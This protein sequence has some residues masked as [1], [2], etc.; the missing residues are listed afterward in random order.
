MQSAQKPFPFEMLS[1]ISVVGMRKDYEIQRSIST[2]QSQVVENILDKVAAY[3]GI[4]PDQIKDKTRV[5]KIVLARSIAQYF[6]RQMLNLTFLEIATMF[7]QDHSTVVHAC[8]NVDR[9]LK[10]KHINEYKEYIED[11]K[12]II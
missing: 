1:Y 9:M 7:E 10:A 5:R 12:Y 11:L 8:Q 3:F 4:K 6:M 2:N